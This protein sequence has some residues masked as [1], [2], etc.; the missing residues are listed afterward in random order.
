MACGGGVPASLT[1]RSKGRIEQR[2]ASFHFGQ[3]H[4]KNE[5][6]TINEMRS[7]DSTVVVVGSWSNTVQE[8]GGSPIA[9]RGF[10]NSVFVQSGNMWK[11]ALNHYYYP[12]AQAP[13]TH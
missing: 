4:V 10:F 12:E 8:T 11:M 13:A 9:A 5:V 2:L 7:F 3:W 1:T 6:I